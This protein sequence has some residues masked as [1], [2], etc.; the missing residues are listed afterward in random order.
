MKISTKVL[1]YISLIFILKV[2]QVGVEP[3][4]IP[5]PKRGDFASLSTGAYYLFLVTRLGFEP[6]VS[7]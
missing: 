5:R 1:K 3:T 7:Q 6:R 4:H 2:P